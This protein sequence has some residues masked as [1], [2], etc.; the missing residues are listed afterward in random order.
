MLSHQLQNGQTADGKPCVD[1]G[2]QVGL[3]LGLRKLVGFS[4]R[5]GRRPTPTLPKSVHASRTSAV[6]WSLMSAVGLSS[7]D[8]QSFSLSIMRW[9]ASCSF[10]A[11]A[12]F[13]IE[14]EDSR[15]RV[16][17]TPLSLAAR[18]SADVLLALWSPPA[19]QHSH[20]FMF[21]ECR[22]THFYARVSYWCR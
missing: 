8:V 9:Y 6:P 10:C 13:L 5:I 15:L 20:T 4:S 7:S 3:G 18:V 21:H 22:M 16:R 1:G 17:P 14:E 11:A 12:E 19:I 2:V